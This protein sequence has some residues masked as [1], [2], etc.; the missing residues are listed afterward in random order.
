MVAFSAGMLAFFVLAAFLT[1]MR[2]EGR[3]PVRFMIAMA[4]AFAGLLYLSV[5]AG[6]G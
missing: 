6:L 1:A 5:S 4:V 3:G 2:G